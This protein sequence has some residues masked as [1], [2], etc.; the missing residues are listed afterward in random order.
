M[1]LLKLYLC[2]HQTTDHILCLLTRQHK[3]LISFSVINSLLEQ[4]LKHLVFARVLPT[5]AWGRT[6]GG[7]QVQISVHFTFTYI[8]CSVHVCRR[9][10]VGT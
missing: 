3:H 7:N 1:I 10:E 5:K 2:L 6:V 4:D 8:Q 9:V